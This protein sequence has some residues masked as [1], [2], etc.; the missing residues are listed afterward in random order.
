[1][2]QWKL[3][4]F[5]RAQLLKNTKF[6][7]I[8]FFIASILLS[9]WSN[10]SAEG[11]IT[12]YYYYKNRP[13]KLTLRT[14][15][16]FVQTKQKLSQN[17]FKSLVGQYYQ[18]APV[19]KFDAN[20]KRQFVELNMP[21]DQSSIDA[22]VKAMNLNPQI[23]YSSPV[24]SPNDNNTVLQGVIDE[25]LV[26]FKTGTTQN[27]ID[28]YLQSNG[29]TITQSLKLTGGAASYV[30]KVPQSLGMYTID[31]AN[32]VYN[33]GLVNWSEPNFYY[34]GL[35]SF[36][37]NDQYYP[38][39]WS[40]K[41]TGSNIPG[42]ISG[43]PGC[44]M[45]VD[46]AWD[47]SLGNS[48]C[49]IGMVDTGIDTLHEDLMANLIPGSGYD[50]INGHPGCWDDYNHGT[51]TAGIVAAVGNNTLGI[52]GIAPGCKLIGIKIFNSSGS[53]STTAITNGLLYSWQQGEWVSSNSWG[54]GSP[55]SAAD[56]AIQDGTTLGRSGKGTVFCFATG[57]GNGALSWPS[58]NAYVVA[59]GG[60]SPCEERK[61]PTS[62]DLESWWGA[63]YGTGLHI[64]TPCVKIYATDRMGSVG[65]STTN[66]YDQFN[67][68][69]SATPNCAGVCALFLSL[70]SMQTWD[71]VRVKL[72]RT[73]DKIGT[74]SYTSTGP[75]TSLGSTWNNEMGYGKVNAFKFLKSISTPPPPVQ[76]D[77]S[78]GPFLS[79]PS[80]FVINTAYSIKT[81]IQ[82]LGT[83]SETAVP[84]K[85][86]IG[87][88]LISTVNKDLAASQV[89]SVSNTWTPAALGSFELMYVSALA[90]DTN[91]ANDTVRTT[92]IVSSQQASSL[93]QAFKDTTFPPAGWLV[94][95]PGIQYWLRAPYGAYCQDS[96]S[97]TF[98]FYYAIPGTTQDLITVAFD[99]TRGLSD[100]L[101]F[102]EAYA[103]Y[104][105]ENDLLV[106]LCQKASD[107]TWIM[108]DTLHGGVS[109]E[110]VTAPPT[111][112]EFVPT[113]IQWKAQSL[114]LP[115]GTNKIKF[116][117]ISAY[118][119][120][121]YVDSV[122]VIKFVGKIPIALLT[123]KVFSL[124]QNYPNPFNPSTKIQYSIPKAGI[125][126][127]VV[128]DLLG[129]EVITLVNEHKQAGVYD[130]IFDGVN[131]A[132][133][134]YFYRIEAGDFTAVKKMVL[135]K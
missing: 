60:N 124:A 43:T 95:P 51:C 96:G 18:T 42:S 83:S 33:S 63:N 119:N 32:M 20:E 81:R 56:Q 17:E 72:C 12:D 117:A 5:S 87:G 2:D 15:K 109:G 57:N 52:S 76:H 134:I 104:A 67:G 120:D 111:T 98:S 34:S 9:G 31:A 64:V 108:L 99:S 24:Y 22:L 74:Y 112:D 100:S 10:N 40:I 105:T 77:I 54:G 102:H 19:T 39:Q 50:F 78:A 16:I 69:S 21:Y 130:A 129:R 59:V 36:T 30:L 48:H 3:T 46:S 61:S 71:S 28:E 106:V 103:T 68:T 122:C 110:L 115:I 93:C 37:P 114:P 116:R 84:I 62:C 127:M 82:N 26:Q 113:C 97:A 70:D 49:V 94:D 107:T 13:Y 125:V 65:Y 55:I 132:S 6:L 73:A 92:V 123:P 29:F 11:N 88:V 135:I 8:L 89:D 79:L 91:R 128:Y 101:I 23:E 86:F 126:K 44:D 85:F 1:M 118:G 66:Y 27:R 121:L 80:T 90:T 75:I 58:T 47:L 25:I 38:M 45:R 4:F 14:E 133:G 131:L 7:P 41:N 53:T 35:L